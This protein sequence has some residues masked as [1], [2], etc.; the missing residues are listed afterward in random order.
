MNAAYAAWLLGLAAFAL[1]VLN[2]HL[3]LPAGRPVAVFRLAIGTILLVEGLGLVVERLQ[4]RRLLR[5]RLARRL[6][7]RGWPRLVGAALTL[8]GM[9][10]AGAGA[11]NVVRGAAGLL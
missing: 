6:R 4:L 2:V 10:W 3:F 1:A 9:A 5:A 7:R 8:L 11:L